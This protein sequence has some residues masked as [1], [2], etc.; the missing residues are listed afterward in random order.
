MQLWVVMDS[1]GIRRCCKA[2]KVH[3]GISEVSRT[4]K[5]SRQVTTCSL[6]FEVVMC[7]CSRFL[8]SLHYNR[9]FKRLDASGRYHVM[10]RPAPD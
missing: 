9:L 7:R 2:S 6:V 3:D 4:F 8:C 1:S 5:H 10:P